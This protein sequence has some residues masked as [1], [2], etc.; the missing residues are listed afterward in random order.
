MLEMVGMRKGGLEPPRVLPHRILNPARLPVPPLSHAA[1]RRLGTVLRSAGLSLEGTRPLPRAQERGASL[2]IAPDRRTLGA[3]TPPSLSA[4][5]G[6]LGRPSSEGPDSPPND[7]E[8]GDPREAPLVPGRDGV[9]S[10]HRGRGYQQIALAHRCPLGGKLGPHAGMHASSPQIE[11]NYRKS[12]EQ[13][14]DESFATCPATCGRGAMH[15]VKKFRGGDRR[16]GDLEIPVLRDEAVEV[17]RVAFGC[18]EHAGVYQRP[19]GPLAT[20][21]WVRVRRSTVSR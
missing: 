1:P 20:T 12:L 13:P 17:E 15:P 3:G 14:F 9:A 21:G 6:P 11:G 18:D 10:G 7:H 5:R 19:H 2:R 8:P 16:D 4:A